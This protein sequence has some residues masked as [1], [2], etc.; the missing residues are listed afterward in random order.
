MEK[1]ML[2][3]KKIAIIGAGHIGQALIE[4]FL[5]NNRKYSKNITIS[6]R[7][8][9][10]LILLRKK[11]HIN[12]TTDNITAVNHADYIFIAVKPFEVKNVI[13]EVAHIAKKKIL[14]SLAAAVSINMLHNYVQNSDYK[15]IRAMPNLSISANKG[16][17]GLYSNN[18]IT[19]D[20]EQ[21]LIQFLSKLG[22]I[23]KLQT[24]ND[25]DKLTIISGCGPAIVSYFIKLLCQYGRFMK[26]SDT[27]LLKMVL[28]VFIGTLKYLKENNISPDH[29][30]SSVSTKGGITETIIADLKL[31]K[32]KHIFNQA[33]NKGNDKIQKI[34]SLL[35]NN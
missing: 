27:V 15:I 2:G 30:I 25:L 26:I 33:M 6:S 18:N 19:L 1:D 4:G 9:S 11:Y 5:K 7:T 31:N 28:Q 20:E 29:L 14:I 22:L 13:K 32:F 17:I 34:K 35:T 8:K 23:I 24:E 12:I 10:K 16:V 3:N 21:I